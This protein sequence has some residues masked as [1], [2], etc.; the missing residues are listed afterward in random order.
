MTAFSN[1]LENAL[2]NATLRNTTYTPAT[3]GITFIA[4]YT[5]DP[6]DDNSGTEITAVSGYDR[7]EVSAGLTGWTTASGGSCR[8]AKHG[9]S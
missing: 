4:L 9:N 3:S 5:S 6:G 2:L 7:F 8:N 1:F